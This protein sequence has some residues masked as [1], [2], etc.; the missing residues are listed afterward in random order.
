MIIA[1]DECIIAPSTCELANE[2][3]KRLFVNRIDH[4]RATTVSHEATLTTAQQ[5]RHAGALDTALRASAK[6]NCALESIRISLETNTNY[7]FV[8]VDST[9]A[10]VLH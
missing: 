4:A 6:A 7:Q 8:I 5:R 3:N 10:A 1:L 9:L 2:C